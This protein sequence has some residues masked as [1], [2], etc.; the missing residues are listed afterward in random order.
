MKKWKNQNDRS[1]RIN[2][3][4]EIPSGSY[5]KK[6][7]DRWASAADGKCIGDKNEEK[8]WKYFGK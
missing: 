6:I 8:K 1:I 4:E 7:N 5:Y 3:D 2:K